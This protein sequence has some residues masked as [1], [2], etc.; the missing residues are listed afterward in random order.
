MH[1]SRILAPVFLIIFLSSLSFADFQSEIVI[2]AAELKEY[3]IVQE[4]PSEMLRVSSRMIQLQLNS[5]G[6]RVTIMPM[7][8]EADGSKEYTFKVESKTCKIMPKSGEL[9]PSGFTAHNMPVYEEQNY[10]V[11]SEK[12]KLCIKS[13]AT[14]SSSSSRSNLTK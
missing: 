2:S 8:F 7:K 10:K 3:R 9:C 1:I 12:Y 13:D 6:C 5:K 4:M 11:G 14:K